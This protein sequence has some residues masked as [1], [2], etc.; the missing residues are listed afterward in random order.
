MEWMLLPL[1]RYAQFNGRSRRKEYW[2]WV[3]FVIL[4]TIVLSIL[5]SMLGLGGRSA[6]GPGEMQGGFS[7]GASVTGGVLA[8]IF[9]VATFVP[10]LAV[11]VRRLHD[12]DRSGWWILLPLLPYLL[13]LVIMV[14]GAMAANPALAMLG[15]LALLVGVICAI[16]LLVWYCSAGT[17][18]PNRFGPDPLG[19]PVEDLEKTFE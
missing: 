17:N 7:Y 19:D 12:I 4:A 13:G 11:A 10:S 9:A 5:D 14:G 3:L 2:M 18:G 16:V 1:K 8:T 15:G 6:V